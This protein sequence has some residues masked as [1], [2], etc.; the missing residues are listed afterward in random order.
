MEVAY[1]TVWYSIVKYIDFIW[2]GVGDSWPVVVYTKCLMGREVE[3]ILKL[4][5]PSG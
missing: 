2:V 5:V 4:T 1:A 3:L